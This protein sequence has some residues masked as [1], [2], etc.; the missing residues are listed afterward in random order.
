MRIGDTGQFATGPYSPAKRY[1]FADGKGRKRFSD[2]FA[3]WL[4][5]NLANN[6]EA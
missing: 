3:L 4:T 5:K 1:D 6:N 2:L